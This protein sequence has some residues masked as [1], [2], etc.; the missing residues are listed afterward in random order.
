MVNE[1]VDRFCES[2]RRWLIVTGVTF[3]AGL[4]TILPQADHFFALSSDQE[5]LQENLT[6]AARA[7]DLLPGYVE[8]VA[9]E[10]KTRQS[11]EER[12]LDAER[13]PV[14]RNRLVDF[15][16]ESGCQLRRINISPA[17]TRPWRQG[18]NPVATEDKQA[19]PTAFLLETRSVVLSVSGG[20]ASINELLQRLEDERLIY[21]A[22]RLD[23]KPAVKNRR[24]VQL[25]LELLC[26]ALT[27]E[28]EAGE[29]S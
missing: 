26:Y 17:K 13:A 4:L 14:F 22:E 18:D 25:D 2:R 23:L 6:L 15:V 11:L 19:K 27:H 21:H 12:T 8:R 9:E 1:L 20:S 24:G 28:S 5:D 7:A 3:V 16:R 10:T 29:R